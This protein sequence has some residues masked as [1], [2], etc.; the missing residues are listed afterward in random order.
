MTLRIE[1]LGVFCGGNWLNNA[2]Y[3]CTS[4]AAAPSMWQVHRHCQ[5]NVKNLYV[6]AVTGKLSLVFFFHDH[7]YFRHL[8]PLSFPHEE[9]V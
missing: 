9:G 3:S 6:R 7:P 5:L 4:L 8:Y 1:D 2:R